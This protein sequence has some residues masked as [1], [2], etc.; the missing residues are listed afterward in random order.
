VQGRVTQI[1]DAQIQAIRGFLIACEHPS[2]RSLSLG[3]VTERTEVPEPRVRT[4]KQGA[5]PVT[6]DVRLA[7]LRLEPCRDGRYPY[8][9][10]QIERL[11]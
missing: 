11:P 5:N 3:P 10:I 9:L 7:L 1:P 2:E 4:L 8:A 6:F